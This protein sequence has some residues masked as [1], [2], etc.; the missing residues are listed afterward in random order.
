MFQIVQRLYLFQID[1]INWVEEIHV[2]LQRK[3]SV[4]EAGASTSFFPCENLVSF[5]KQYFLQILTFT[6]EKGSFFFQIGLFTWDVRT[7]VSQKKTFS[8]RNRSILHMFSLGEMS[9]FL[10]EYILQI[11]IFKL[12]KGS[13]C[14]NRPNQL[15]WR[16]TC[17]SPNNTTYASSCSY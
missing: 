8:V 14:P 3:P 10:K 6:V 2:S 16:K 11:R 9:Y 1:P 4:L 17:I 5:W 13:F 12:E 7:H 15:S